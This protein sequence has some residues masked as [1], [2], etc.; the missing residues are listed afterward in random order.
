VLASE[1]TT[2]TVRYKATL[3][4]FVFDFPELFTSEGMREYLNDEELFTAIAGRLRQS[5]LTIVIQ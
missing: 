4:K 5:A 2:P 3:V 1:A